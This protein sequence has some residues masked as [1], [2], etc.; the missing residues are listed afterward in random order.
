MLGVKVE[1]LVQKA[2]E[3][4]LAAVQHYNNPT[5]VFRSGNYVVLMIIGYTALFHAIFECDGIDYVERKSDDTPKLTPD[6]EEYLWDVLRCARHYAQLY[7][8][9][10]EKGTLAAM[11]KNLEFIFPIRHKIE[12]RHMPELDV[13]ICG[14]CQAMLLNFEQ[15]ITREFTHYYALNPSLNLALQFSTRR[16]PGIITAIK[17]FQSAEYAALQAYISR[18]H[19]DLPDDIA[20][21]TAFEFRVWLIQKPA[22]RERG[23]DLSIE[24]VRTDQLSDEDREKFQEAIVA[25]K[26]VPSDPSKGCNLWEKDVVKHVQQRI[27]LTVQFGGQPKKLTN[28]MIRW[29]RDAHGIQS[30]SKMY[31]RPGLD[32]SRAMYSPAFVEWLVE[33]YAQEPEFFYNAKLTIEQSSTRRRE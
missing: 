3:S 7:G 33:Q 5:A 23:A 2:R 13:D 21:N 32:G 31:Y 28:T 27:G 12:H 16:S 4:V 9:R 15:I 6:G 29:A 1:E 17:R 22:N 14:H 30:P 25:V 18:F 11:A 20:G 10:Y 26:V 8:D 24:F 19:A